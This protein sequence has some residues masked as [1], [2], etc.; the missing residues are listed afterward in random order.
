M[1]LKAGP[2]YSWN[3][4]VSQR[5]PRRTAGALV[6]FC[7]LIWMLVK[8]VHSVCENSSRFSLIFHFLYVYYNFQKIF[9]KRILF[10]ISSWWRVAYTWMIVKALSSS[11]HPMA[12]GWRSRHI[13]IPLRDLNSFYR[14]SQRQ[15][16]NL[17][18]FP[19]LFLQPSLQFYEKKTRNLLQEMSKCTWEGRSSYSAGHGSGG[20]LVNQK[21]DGAHHE[22]ISQGRRGPP[23]ALSHLYLAARTLLHSSLDEHFK[24]PLVVA[25]MRDA[26]NQDSSCLTGRPCFPSNTLCSCC[27][28]SILSAFHPG[29]CL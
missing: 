2:G 10:Y 27:R 23:L 13:F 5:G 1:L 3:R 24:K 21:A 22:H 26:S 7:F 9:Q 12:T 4:V 28:L 17:T 25:P 6:I 19:Y 8:R 16:C 18:P 11:I 14:F 29:S 15:C 20:K